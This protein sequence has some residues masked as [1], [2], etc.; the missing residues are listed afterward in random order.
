MNRRQLLAL[1]LL[2]VPAA[3]R[4]AAAEGPEISVYLNPN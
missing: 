2:L 1:P 3:A 4:A